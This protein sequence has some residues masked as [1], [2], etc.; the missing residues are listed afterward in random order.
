M[1]DKTQK[2]MIQEL[3]QAIVG[4][5]DNPDDNGLIGE[6]KE[7]KELLKEQNKR[8]GKNEG[9]VSKLQGI[10]IGVG[11]IGTGGLGV[12]ISQLIGG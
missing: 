11:V 6:F 10:L 8:I 12:G 2:E 7:V 5:D 9:K 1:T 4:I 3:R